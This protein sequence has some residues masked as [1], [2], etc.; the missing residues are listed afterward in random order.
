MTSIDITIDRREAI[1]ER[2]LAIGSGISGIVSSWRDHGPTQTG[3]L[4]VPRPAF[5][6]YDGGTSLAQRVEPHKIALMPTTI[7]CMKPQIVVLLPNRDTVENLVLEGSPAPVG[8]ELSM[9]SS[10]VQNEVTNDE[11]IVDLVTPNGTHFINAVE[12]DMQIGRAL[13]AYGA[14]VML[15]YHFY[16]PVFR[17]Q[18]S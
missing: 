6:L 1:L 2:L 16:Y 9:W 17:S 15:L 14:W 13:G 7:W 10:L 11:T 4:G 3:N 18:P 12:T 5:L 8:P